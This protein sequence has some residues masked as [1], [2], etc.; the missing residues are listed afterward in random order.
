MSLALTGWG[1]ISSL[2]IGP[3]GFSEGFRSG[4][5]ERH[6]VAQVPDGLGSPVETAALAR[7]FDIATILGSKKG[8]RVLDRTAALA[9]GATTLA[10]RDRGGELSED[11]RNHW[12]V[13]LGTSNGSFTRTVEYTTETLSPERPY[14]VSP[15]AFPNTVMNFAAGQCAI[16]HGLR[17]LNATIS[18]GRL[19]CLLALRYARRMLDAG[20]ARG[21]VVGSVEEFSG[22]MAWGAFH[23]AAGRRRDGLILG[24]GGAMFTLEPSDVATAHARAAVLA[25]EV[26][27]AVGGGEQQAQALASC[28]QAA[29]ARA[30]V[31]AEEVSAISSRQSGLVELD[32]V[33]ERALALVF[34]GKRAAQRLAI[35][36]QA[37]ET[38][39]A[40][41]ALQLSALLAWFSERP[42]GSIG[43][44]TSLAHSGAVGCAVLRRGQ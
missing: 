31:T 30:E 11:T 40:S 15:E 21:I 7:D 36:R 6:P 28:I 43:I 35:A 17:A 24:E 37:G 19:A 42:T 1:V 20:Y 23:A 44:V 25:C 2:G 12:G 26:R 5:S 14:M 38:F 4:R 13:V 9:L 39:S 41:G 3:D 32:S 10:L 22:T 27:I 33:E 34:D 29:L 18:G 16:W 8:T